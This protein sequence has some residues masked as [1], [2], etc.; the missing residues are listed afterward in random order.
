MCS[1]S[2]DAMSVEHALD[3]ANPGNAAHRYQ[4]SSC[5]LSRIDR[6]FDQRHR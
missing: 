2:V 6:H 3:V 4:L 5:F 1:G